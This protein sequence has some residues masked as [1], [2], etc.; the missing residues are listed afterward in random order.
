[1]HTLS[2]PEEFEEVVDFAT[3]SAYQLIDF[4]NR[5]YPHRCIG[6]SETEIE[7]HRYAG[8]RELIDDL[9]QAKSDELA[10]KSD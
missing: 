4:L 10:A 9:L 5:D 1:M 6:K 2:L 3:M 8:K 7:A